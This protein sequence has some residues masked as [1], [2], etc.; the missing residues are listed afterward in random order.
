MGRHATPN[1]VPAA[2]FAG[3]RKPDYSRI[4]VP[5]LA[6]FALPNPLEEQLQRY[7]PKDADERAA[8]ENV[9]AADVAF[10]KRSIGVLH[11]GVPGARIVELAGATHHVF[12]SNEPDVLREVRVFLA[13]LK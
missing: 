9:Y 8:I 5:V 2:I 6:F 11:S 10:E 12:L 3:M 7:Q 13:S 1:S 4:R